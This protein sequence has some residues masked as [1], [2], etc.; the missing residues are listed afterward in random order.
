MTETI[1][2]ALPPVVFS[3]HPE[4]YHH[5]RLEVQGE[6]AT[7]WLDVKDDKPLREG[8]VLKLNSYDL[9]VDIELADAVERLRFEHPAVKVVVIRSAKDRV[10]SAGANIHMLG[11]SAHGFKINFCKFT[12]ET[13]LGIEDASR[14]SGLRFLAA[15]NG[16]CAGGGYELALA[17]DD[18][19]LVDDGSS[20]V[21]LP[22]VSLL[23]VLPG[24][25]GLTRVVDKRRV[26]RDHADIFCTL[27]E[28]VRGQR[29]VDWKLVDAVAPRSR[30]EHTVGE[31]ARVLA[32]TASNRTGPGVVLPL[33]EVESTPDRRAYRYVTVDMHRAG[34]T[35]TLTV[36][37]PGAGEPETA[38]AYRARGAHAW[39]FRAFRELEDAIL[40]L[41]FNEETLGLVVI[42]TEG[43]LDR[44]LAVDTTLDR[45]RDDWFVRE[46]L[47]YQ[48]RV[49]RRLDLTAR[50]LFALVEPGSCFGGCL[51]ELVLAADRSYLLDGGAEPRTALGPLNARDYSMTH[52]LTRLAAHFSGDEGAVRAAL[53]RGTFSPAEAEAAGVVTARLDRIDYEDEVRVAIEERASLSPDALTGMEA[54]LRFPGLENADAK[55]FGRLSAWQNWIFFRPNAVGEHGALKV[56]GKP[57]RAAFD[58]R[59]T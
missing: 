40:W 15:L 38:E 21:S 24:T 33:L 54:S 19:V 39:A 50:S 18:L 35:A 17:C 48:A 1:S 25:G 58:W 26:R 16:I 5:W 11:L 6:I 47:L 36:R 49:L 51:F 46:V 44:V 52:G 59:R 42:R 13:R 45:L 3:T 32:A 29:A 22:E 27:Q 37:G 31:R 57:E 12:N 7:L 30:F 43:D 56:Y 55:I 9:G 8:Y 14:S 34:R 23:G 2:T 28:G 20:A 41:R 4:R 10:F 53:G